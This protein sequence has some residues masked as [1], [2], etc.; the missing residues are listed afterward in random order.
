MCI[1]EKGN[2]GD[3]VRY[4]FDV[5]SCLV[6]LSLSCERHYHFYYQYYYRRY[7][8]IV[9]TILITYA[10]AAPYRTIADTRERLLLA[11]ENTIERSH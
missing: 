7:R 6:Y 8:C 4:R 3:I 11:A 9:I 5:A 10:R 2:A 1:C